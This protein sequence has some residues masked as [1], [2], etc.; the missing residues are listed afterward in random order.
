M[1]TA[2]KFANLNGVLYVSAGALAGMHNFTYQGGRELSTGVKGEGPA[3]WF[4]HNIG[5]PGFSCSEEAQEVFATSPLAGDGSHEYAAPPLPGNKYAR[6][7]SRIQTLDPY[8]LQELYQMHP[9][10]EHVVKKLLCAGSRSGGKSI[11]TDIADCIQTLQRWQ[12]MRKED[13]DNAPVDAADWAEAQRPARYDWAPVP[14]IFNFV[15][16]DSDGSIYM[17]EFQPEP[18]LNAWAT[19]GAGCAR[20][21]PLSTPAR[22]DTPDWR[23]SLERRP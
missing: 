2:P 9:C 15:A 12:D 20:A 11:D 21:H 23:D 1:S 22:V 3:G 5:G 8:R 16:T 10:A 7:V 14:Q 18:G 19:Y 13:A 6:D 4:K 17:Y